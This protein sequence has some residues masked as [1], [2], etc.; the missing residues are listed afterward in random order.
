MVVDM[1]YSYTNYKYRPT[2][3]QKSIVYK[4]HMKRDVKCKKYGAKKHL[5]RK[6]M[7]KIASSK[8]IRSWFKKIAT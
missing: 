8:Q 4:I 5:N 3:K 1:Q 6:Q 2:L 7:T